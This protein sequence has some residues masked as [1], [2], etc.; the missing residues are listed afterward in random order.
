MPKELVSPVPTRMIADHNARTDRLYKGLTRDE[1]KFG[2]H[3]AENIDTSTQTI[4]SSGVLFDNKIRVI[5]R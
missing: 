1:I 5:K 3:P 2:T 4:E